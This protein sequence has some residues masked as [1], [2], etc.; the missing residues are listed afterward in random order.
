[1]DDS[2]LASSYLNGM[3]LRQI[4]FSTGIPVATIWRR[5]RWLGVPMRSR[6]SRRGAGRNRTRPSRAAVRL[7]LAQGG[8]IASI[9]RRLY[10]SESTIRLLAQ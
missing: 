1:M 4:S 5:L 9:A 6:G 3:S 2:S 7:S 10:C 8:S